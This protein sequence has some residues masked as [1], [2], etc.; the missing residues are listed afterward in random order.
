MAPNDFR[1]DIE[2][3]QNRIERLSGE[4]AEIHAKVAETAVKLERQLL[5]AGDHSSSQ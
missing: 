2:D 1:R 3:M 4:L 5:S